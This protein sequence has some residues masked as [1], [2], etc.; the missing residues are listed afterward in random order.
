MSPPR[1]R[2]AG[3]GP[4][5]GL[6]AGRACAQCG[7]DLRGSP[8]GGLCPECGCPVRRPPRADAPFDEMPLS[9]IRPFRRSCRLATAA[10]AGALGAQAYVLL[11][12]VSDAT[13]IAAAIVLA[14]SSALW[15]GAC[16]RL[17]APMDVP[18]AAS[19]GLGE[20]GRLR[21]LARWLQLGWLAH[22]LAAL[23]D[24]TMGPAPWTVPLVL[25]A[26][27]VG[28]AGTFALAVLL[29]RLAW[30]V[31][32]EFAHKALDL[33]VWGT[34]TG[35]VL[36][37]I[38][39][40]L[41]FTFGGLTYAIIPVAAILVGVLVIVSLLAFPVGLL[42]LARSVEWAALH[43]RDRAERNRELAAR[44]V[45]RPGPAAAGGPVPPGPGG[46]S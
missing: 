10:L 32:D 9:L 11:F 12:P 4:P 24:V 29:S 18:A 22:G 31:R 30:W 27:P 33:V 14:A 40:V 8:P 44:L 2:H 42:S 41:Q 1:D 43:A 16:F 28:L 26:W 46:R 5:G 19:C 25:F 39:P 3:A 20:R 7:Y 38:I 21:R 35:T 45:R 36:G 15:V 34:A 23:H 13:L 6:Q 17:T 37:L